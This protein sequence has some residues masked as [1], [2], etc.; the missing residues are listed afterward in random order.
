MRYAQ[1]NT[2]YVCGIDLHAREMYIC[3][4]NRK[5]DILLHRNLHTDFAQFKKKIT[6]FLPDISVGVESTYFYYWLAD[7]CR[8]HGIPFYLGHAYYMKTIH[9]GKTKTDRLDCAKIA[10]LMRTNYFPLAH[11][12]PKEMRSTRD[13]LRRRHRLS[14]LRAE[15]YRHIQSLFHQQGLSINPND[16]KNRYAR[17]SLV[18][19]LADEHVQSNANADLDLVDF[20]DP[21]VK[22]LEQEIRGQAKLQ[23]RAALNILLS[24]PGIGDML[25]LVILYEI[26]DINRFESHQK[27]CSYARLV[28]CERSS[29]GKRTK[30]GNQKIGNPYLKWAIGEIIIHAAHKSQVIGN[31]YQK[32]QQ[33][34]GK[35][36]ALNMIT[37]KFGIAIYYMLK[38]KQVFDENRF[39]QC[40]MK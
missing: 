22:Q 32:L 17:R 27:F 28:K 19:N 34:C 3:V 40:D 10:D 11:T 5:G 29:A 15:C 38:N 12:Y 18:A 6:P 35:K 8:E 20:L 16:V 9:G 1:I 30:G 21:V 33:R 13:L 36:K 24:V 26:N 37:H 7:A 23:D 2:P 4:K 25:S 39:V 14:R 31:Y